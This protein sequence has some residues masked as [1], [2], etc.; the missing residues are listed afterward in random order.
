GL[1]EAGPVIGELVE[2]LSA[3]GIRVCLDQQTAELGPPGLHARCLV[4]A[5]REMA[6]LADALVVLGGDGTLLAA[7][8]LLEKPIPVLGVNF[9]SL[10]FLTEIAL[11]ELYPT[12]KGV[13]EGRSEHEERRLLRARIRRRDR[14]EAE[15]DVLNDV[16]ITKAG[17]SRIIEVDLAVDGLFVSSFRADGIIVSSPTGSTAYNLAAGGPILHPTLPALVV[18]P[19]CPHMLTNRPLV[20]SDESRVEVRLRAARDVEVYAALDGQETFAFADGDS[21]E[22]SGSPRRLQLVK[23]PGRDYYQVLRSKLKWGDAFTTERQR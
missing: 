4:A 17:P 3:R 23:A 14:P 1:R 7:S 11:P 8:R 15:T 13:L 9:G 18:T 2:W 21:V 12:L 22:V 20:V 10:G 5:G 16:V 19:I 6:R